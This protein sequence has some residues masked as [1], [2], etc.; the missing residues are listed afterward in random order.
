MSEFS[1]SPTARSDDEWRE[2]LSPEQYRV[3]RQAGTERPFGPTYREFQEQGAGTYVCAGCGV[4]L[5]SSREKFDSHCG[6]PSFYDPANAQNVIAREDRSHGAV[7]TEV[8][9]ASCGGHLGHVF[10]GEGFNTP[11][12]QRYCINGVALKF[13]PAEPAQKRAGDNPSGRGN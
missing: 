12:D 7:R 9:C 10:A 1:P 4:S 13:V 11:T 8:L 3:L 2:L 5:F 6:W